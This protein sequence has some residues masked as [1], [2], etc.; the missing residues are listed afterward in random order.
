MCRGVLPACIIMYHLCVWY[1]QK[2]KEVV[3]PPGARATDS[4]EVPYGF[5]ESNLGLLEKQLLSHLFSP[6]Y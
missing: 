4:C 6:A 3:G 1:F 5:W 2:P